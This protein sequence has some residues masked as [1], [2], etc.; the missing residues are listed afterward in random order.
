MAGW[1][2]ISVAV[3]AGNREGDIR[4]RIE[5]LKSAREIIVAGPG[6]SDAV[7]E[8]AH[9]ITDKVFRC[10]GASG[11][12][13]W[14]L[15]VEKATREWVLV[16]EADERVPPDLCEEM[17]S[18]LADPASDC[19][20]YLIPRLTCYCGRWMRHGGWYPDYQLRLFRRGK[21]RFREGGAGHEMILD[22]PIRKLRAHLLREPG[23]GFEAEIE[24]INRASD[25][26]A[27][28]LAQQGPKHIVAR[29]L[30]CPIADFIRVYLIAAGI[31]DGKQG[32]LAA[33]MSS[34][35]SFLRYA[36][37]W[38]LK[39]SPQKADPA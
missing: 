8:A 17:A 11:P 5:G 10:G 33:M 34:F 19:A 36:K 30:L 31:L 29:M 39:H 32:F 2:D 15:A 4:R 6:V 25:E 1:D 37:L 20:G 27:R 18:A 38:E 35:R 28:L 13:P 12:D 3:I 9:P 14:R 16:V 7:A 26:D 24:R 21:A 23:G 22:G